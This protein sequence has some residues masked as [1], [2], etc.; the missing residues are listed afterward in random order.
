MNTLYDT[1]VIGGGPAGMIA[2]GRAAELGKKVI[3]LEKNPTL[4]KKLLITGGGR[5]NITNSNIPLEKVY[6]EAGKYLHTTFAQFNA[7]DTLD[8]F[9]TRDM[10][11]HQEALGRIF[12]T[13][14]RSESVLKVLTDYMDQGRVE[15]RCNSS[16]SGVE[17]E[18]KRFSIRLTSGEILHSI[19]CIV[20]TGGI[21]HPETG[22]TGDGFIWL[23]DL[24]HTIIENDFALVPIALS[25]K[26]CKALSGLTLQ[27]IKLTVSCDG[28]KKFSTL[29]RL[30]FT[31]FGIS[32][33]TIL[34]MS[35]R[36]GE[37]LVTGEVVILIDL[38]PSID[39]GALR[40][41]LN[42]I[43][44]KEKNKQI[45]NSLKDLLPS[46]LIPTLLKMSNIAPDSYCHS[47]RKEERKNFVN[48]LKEIPLNPEALLGA[49]KAI[50]SSGGVDA[51]EIDF[52]RM[53]SKIV[54]NLFLVGDVVNIDRP[55]GG[56]SLQ[57]CWTTGYVAGTHC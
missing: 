4:G 19:S 21:S 27:D 1:I 43:L 55:S 7:E 53:E 11:T 30:L 17:I 24:G 41:K 44:L 2:A 48:L 13:S 49:D 9:H 36:I 32:G 52:K 12:P 26:W 57:L 22:S 3:L 54:K 15:I 5:C 6:K 16:V 8:F 42:E 56:F 40:L 46:S 37:L 29:G 31:H 18:E 47:V 34:N 23:K 28:E 20:A 25:D 38:F 45:K 33:P 50:I 35:K 39:H 10:P 14:N 51:K